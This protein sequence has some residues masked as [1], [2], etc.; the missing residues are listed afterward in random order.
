MKKTI[1]YFMLLVFAGCSS[2]TTTYDYDKNADFTKFKTYAYDES[3]EKLPIMQLDKDRLIAAVD[4][5]MQARGFSKSDN[6]DMLVGLHVTTHQGQ[7]ATATTTGTGMYGGPWRY[8]YGGG[9]TTTSV[10]VENYTDGTL[11]I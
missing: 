5:E 2:I 11:F 7:T 3:A 10:N 4:R 8:G 6:P 1:T 9:F